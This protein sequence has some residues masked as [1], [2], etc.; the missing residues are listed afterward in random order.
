[1]VTLDKFARIVIA[2]MSVECLVTSI[3]FASSGNW[4][5]AAYWFFACGINIVGYT[6]QG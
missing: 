5:L 3:A 6:L 1:M 4:K 2:V